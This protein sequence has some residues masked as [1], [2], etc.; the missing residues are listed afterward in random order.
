MEKEQP[1]GLIDI[2]PESTNSIP[3]FDSSP[4]L[5]NFSNFFNGQPE[6]LAVTYNNNNNNNHTNNDASTFI[7]SSERLKS[8][9]N[10]TLC[11]VLLILVSGLWLVAGYFVQTVTVIYDSPS[12]LAYLS[13]ISLQI[14][15]LFIP[16]RPQFP[17]RRP[18]GSLIVNESDLTYDTYSNREV[19]KLK[20]IFVFQC[21]YSGFCLYL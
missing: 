20:I 21:I 18:D 8:P 4:A 19:K 16:R 14:Y 5:T 10:L 3:S 1:L 12:F 2:T 6:P 7:S 9:V 17:K 15:F 13:I 11:S